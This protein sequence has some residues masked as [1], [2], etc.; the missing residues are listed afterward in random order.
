[1]PAP[2]LSYFRRSAAYSPPRLKSRSPALSG[3]P[4]RGRA[5]THGELSS[6]RH[7]RGAEPV[8]RPFV[9]LRTR[10]AW[11]NRSRASCTE[12]GPWESIAKF[13][14]LL[15]SPRR[16]TPSRSR[17]AARVGK[18]DFLA[19]SKTVRCR[20][21]ARSGDWRIGTTGCR[22]ALKPGRWIRVLSPGRGARPRLYGGRF[23]LDPETFGRA[24]QDEPAR[25]GHAGATGTA[26]RGGP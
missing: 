9:Q 20:S 14:W 6:R 26:R 11:A 24:H 4:P 16:S 10:I 25:G 8:A 1:M 17:K 19:M 3:E 23:G 18:S 13:L 2:R 12:S 15:M 22:S 5:R 21:N 7:V